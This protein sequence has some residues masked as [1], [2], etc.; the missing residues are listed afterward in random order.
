MISSM[1]RHNIPWGMSSIEV[2]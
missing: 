2:R 1:R